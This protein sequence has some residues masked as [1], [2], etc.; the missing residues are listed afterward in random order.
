[1]GGALAAPPRGR[2]ARGWGGSTPAGGQHTATIEHNCVQ[3][4]FV[5]AEPAVRLIATI[6]LLATIGIGEGGV[7]FFNFTCE[8]ATHS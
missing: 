5:A 1:M 3:R 2:S 8:A 7:W 4:T 6:G